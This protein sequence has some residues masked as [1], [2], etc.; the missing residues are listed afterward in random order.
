MEVTKEEYLALVNTVDLIVIGLEGRPV[1]RPDRWTTLNPAGDAWEVTPEN[2]ILKDEFEVEELR[3][4]KIE[5][6]Q[7]SGGLNKISLEDAKD[8]IDQ[9]FS[10][11]PDSDDMKQPTIL[12][13]KKLVTYILK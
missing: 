11:V 5:A 10:G 1:I 12:A 9:I 2:Q 7:E 6:A 8:K 13:F 4:S 3:K